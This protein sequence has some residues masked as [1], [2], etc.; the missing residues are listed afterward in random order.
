MP[1]T[2][3]DSALKSMNL[4]VN[5]SINLKLKLKLSLNSVDATLAGA[6]MAFGIN[7]A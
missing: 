7:L 5:L 6:R 1:I 4:S 3:R 2:A